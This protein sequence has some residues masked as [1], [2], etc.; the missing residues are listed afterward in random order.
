[1]IIINIAQKYLNVNSTH[2][3]DKLLNSIEFMPDHF[4]DD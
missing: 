2:Y 3:L 1:M 4:V